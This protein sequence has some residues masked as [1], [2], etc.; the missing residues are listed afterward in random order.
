MI[1]EAIRKPVMVLSAA[2]GEGH[3]RAAEALSDA[4]ETQGISAT[5]LEVLQYTNPFF[6]RIYAEYYVNTVN[7]RPWLLGFAYHEMARPYRFERS[8]LLFD[9]LHTRHLVALLRRKTPDLALC[10]H[11]LPAEILLSE[12]MRNSLNVRIGIVMTDFDKKLHHL[13]EHP[14]P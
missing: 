6:R 11:F 7:R 10:T 2:S 3:V 5:H 12:R 9:R 14:I 1:Q 13:L 4:F 8:R